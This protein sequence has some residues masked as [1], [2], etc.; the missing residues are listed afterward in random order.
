[1]ARTV[2]LAGTIL[3]VRSVR[4]AGI[5]R[6]AKAIRV[7]RA[8]RVTGAIWIA[9]GTCLLGA[10]PALIAASTGCS[11][12]GSGGR[13]ACAVLSVVVLTRIRLRPTLLG[14][15]VRGMVRR[16]VLLDVRLTRLRLVAV[17]ALGALVSLVARLTSLLLAARLIR[18]GRLPACL[19]RRRLLGVG[20]LAARLARLA[21]LPVRSF[22]VVSSSLLPTGMGG[23]GLRGGGA[24]S[25]RGCVHRVLRLSRRN[26]GASLGRGDGWADPSRAAGLGRE[27]ARDLGTGSAVASGRWAATAPGGT[28][29]LIR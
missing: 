17:A 10:R 15:T 21:M 7:A 25:V 27:G 5:T 4:V 3:L 28:A 16:L 19:I 13:S 20:L 2:V 23:G 18:R 24:A 11:C 9:G 8:V 29:V 1:M 6:V 12:S 22:A 26:V 14:H